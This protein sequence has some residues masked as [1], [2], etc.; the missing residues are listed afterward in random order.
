M[1]ET[2]Y[3]ELID[4]N[5]NV[6]KYEIIMSFKLEETNKYYVVYTDNSINK[7]N[8]INIYAAIYDPFDDSKFEKITTDK[9]WQIIE[10]QVKELLP[11]NDL[12]IK[13]KNT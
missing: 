11:K 8:S 6:I 3:L 10:A 7:D 2:K 4:E 9:E 12:I 13:N 1:R 5:N